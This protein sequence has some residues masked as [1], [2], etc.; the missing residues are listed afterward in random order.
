MSEKSIGLSELTDSPTEAQIAS[1]CFSFRHDFGLLP[2]SERDLM[3][4]E[5]RRWWKVITD[6]ITNP[7]YMSKD[8]ETIKR[9]LVGEE[10][11]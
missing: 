10:P 11:S 9:F 1:V 8:P 5:A 6:E 3:M 7:S 4:S 2:P